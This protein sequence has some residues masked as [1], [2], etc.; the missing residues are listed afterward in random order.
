MNLGETTCK[1]ILNKS[2]IQGVEYA[3]NPYIG[4][5]HGCVY[6][7]ARFMTRWYH[8]G[9]EWG[10]FVDVKK[11]AVECLRKEISIKTPGT[12]LLS[13]VTDPYQPAE[14]ATEITRNI[15]KVLSD[16]IFPVNILTK[17]SLVNRDI[18]V[19]SDMFEVEVGFTITSFDDKVRRVFE[20]NASPVEERIQAL[21]SFSQ[22]GISTYAF[23]GPLL[24]YLSDEKLEL[25]LN[26]LA[27]KVNRV[28]VDRLNI[29]AGNWS[30]IKRTL[31]DNYPDLL[32]R[33]K[34]ASSENSEYYD[35]LRYSVGKMLDKR[36]I[37]ADILF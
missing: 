35:E 36:A 30:K 10:S 13:S 28:I 24:P 9:E 26:S 11:N 20:P 18:D 17:S 5:T 6:C 1:N 19:I 12:I 2:G 8:Q 4:C 31:T 7:Y 34:R 3:I 32:P 21:G 22:I 15:L 14:R 16:E 37:E 33:F 27:D 25:L 29:K 23:L